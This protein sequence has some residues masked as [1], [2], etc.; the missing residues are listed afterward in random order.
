M[1]KLLFFALLI[2]TICCY[3]D[4][5]CINVSQ[6]SLYPNPGESTN[7]K[8]DYANSTQEIE[9]FALQTFYEAFSGYNWINKG[10]WMQSNVSFCLWGGIECDENCSVRTLNI[11]KNNLIGMFPNEMSNFSNLRYIYLLCNSIMGGL[12]NIEKLVS[13]EKL[14]LN[15]NE[16]NDVLPNL[17]NSQKITMLTMENNYIHGTIPTSYSEL[18]KLEIINLSHNFLSGNIPG[19]ISK[20][21]NMI[22]L[23]NNN[24]SGTIPLNYLLLNSLEYLYLDHNNMNGSVYQVIKVSNTVDLSNNR[25]DGFLPN[26]TPSTVINLNISNND[27]KGSLSGVSF[28]NYLIDLRGNPS[29]SHKID[30]SELVPTNSYVITGNLLC[31]Y[32]KHPIINHPIVFVDPDYYDYM[33]CLDGSF[34]CGE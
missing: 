31:P 26:L 15:N 10:L 20:V 4:I 8:C 18:K 32:L 28:Y 22:N 7:S 3:N 2:S 19:F 9:K 11:Q 30:F 23:S 27:L 29:I 16:I 25:F 5:N 1:D 21:L 12:V 17:N 34:L 6:G 33:Y 14:N 24:L 13:L